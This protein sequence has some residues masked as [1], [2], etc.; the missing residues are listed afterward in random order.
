MTSGLPSYRRF[1]VRLQS[2]IS[3]PFLLP[4]QQFWLR[5]ESH[6]QFLQ[7][8]GGQSTSNKPAERIDPT[9]GLLILVARLTARNH[10]RIFSLCHYFAIMKPVRRMNLDTWDK[11]KW[12]D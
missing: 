12:Q 6:D 2:L 4:H 3:Q 10:N 9:R 1:I 5:H 8:G 7:A 11:T